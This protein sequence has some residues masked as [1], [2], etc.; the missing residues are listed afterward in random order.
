MA[1]QVSGSISMTSAASRPSGRIGQASFA[2]LML[3]LTV[4]F[5]SLGVWQL[6]RLGEKEA[7]IAAVETRLTGTPIAFPPAAQ[8]PGLAP[9]ALDYR[10]T[11]LAGTFDHTRTILVFTNLT[12]PQGQFGRTGYWVM[13]PLETAESGIVWIN[14]GFVP[15]HLASAWGDGGLAPQGVVEIEGVIRKPEE[16]NPFTPGPDFDA[17][18]EW[19]RDPLRLSEVARID[20]VPVAPV[21]IDLPAGEPGQLPQ[22][23]ETQ[24]SFPNR[25]LEYAGTWFIF[26]VIT[27]VMLGYWLWRQRR[28]TNLAQKSAR[29]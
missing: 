2:L 29:D 22:G 12:D 28:G 24:V 27:P 19:V 1:I 8:W 20:G 6:Q 9:E 25:H 10:N 4:L 15:E 7:L 26:A 23:G 14:R 21:T 5:V 13:A 16:A 18:R 17:R 11:T 3:M